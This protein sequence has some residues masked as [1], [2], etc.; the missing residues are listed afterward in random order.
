MLRNIWKKLTNREAVLYIIFGVLTTLV[1][2]VSYAAFWSMGLDYRVSTAL[3][4]AA[5]VLFAFVTNKLFVFRSFEMRLTYLWKEFTAFVACRLTTGA[6][7]MLGMVITVDVLHLN[8][9]V[10][11]FLVSVMS[12]VLNYV[13]SKL[14]IFKK[15]SDSGAK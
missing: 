8:E 7:T 3:S 10:G 1:D 2:W 15:R 9:F 12:L 14:F 11:K 6:L 5:A 4:W 13:F